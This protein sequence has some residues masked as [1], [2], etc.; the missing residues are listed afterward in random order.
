MEIDRNTIGGFGRRIRKNLAFMLA[1]RERGE[2]VHVVTELMIALLGLI[3]F[4][5]EH[6]KDTRALNFKKHRLDD[7][8]AHGWPH[9][10]FQIGGSANLDNLIYHLRNALSHRRIKFSSD[11]RALEGVQVTFWDRPK[12]AAADNWSASINAAALL[13]FVRRFSQLIDDDTEL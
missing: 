8:A 2:D 13:D 5:Y 4:P 3:V 12:A 9:W 10:S 7:L 11:D 1:A 6:F